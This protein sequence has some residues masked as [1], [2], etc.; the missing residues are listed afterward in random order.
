MEKRPTRLQYPVDKPVS[1]STSPCLGL[2]SNHHISKWH[3]CTCTCVS[4]S[5][6]LCNIVVNIVMLL[7]IRVSVRLRGD[8]A[9]CVSAEQLLKICTCISSCAVSMSWA[10]PALRIVVHRCLRLDSRLDN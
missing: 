4:C 8:N 1:I 3:T 7:H 5:G 6:V 10:W 9:V 2:H